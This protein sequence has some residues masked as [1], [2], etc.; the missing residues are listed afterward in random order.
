MVPMIRKKKAEN[1]AVHFYD[2]LAID[3]DE[4]TEFEL[5]FARER[6]SIRALIERYNL[7]T[8]LDAGCGTGF[9][10]FLLSQL[11]LQVTAAD[12]SQEML[13]RTRNHAQGLGFRIEIIHSTFPELKKVLHTKFDSVFCLGNTL[14]HLL[15][16]KEFF[17]S[18][19]SFHKVLNPQGIIFIQILNYARILKTRER[20]QSIKEAGGNTFVRFYDYENETIRFNILTIKKR[21]EGIMHS[22][23]S[24]LLRP[25]TGSDVAR[26]LRRAGFFDVKLFGSI[27][28]ADYDAHSSKD[29]VVFA[30][31]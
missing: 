19:R 28:M 31:T 13:K 23:N 14:A 24:V 11:G 25:W 8:A 4:M 20:I 29:L 1:S 30:H 5:R 9:H 6:S 3:Y 17:E 22:L 15:T 7:K 2:A 10:S 27:A 18:L 16:A 12:I 21:E 26:L